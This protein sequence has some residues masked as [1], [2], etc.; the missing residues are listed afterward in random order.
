MELSVIFYVLELRRVC[1]SF[2]ES[3]FV[4]YMTLS[5]L[6]SRIKNI[7]KGMFPHEQVAYHPHDT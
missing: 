7:R 4:F 5:T 2:L 1:Q 6:N 3:F